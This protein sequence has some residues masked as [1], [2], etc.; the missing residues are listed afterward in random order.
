MRVLFRPFFLDPTIPREGMSRR[1]A[2]YKMV[3]LVQAATAFRSSAGAAGG[4]GDRVSD[5]AGVCF[6]GQFERDV[7]GR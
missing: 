7:A 4:G 3:S 2:F 6:V 1:H 5:P